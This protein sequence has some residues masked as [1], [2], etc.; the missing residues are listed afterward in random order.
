MDD[1]EQQFLLSSLYRMHVYMN[2][3]HR[4][5]M[6]TVRFVPG[7]YTKT[8]FSSFKFG[9]AFEVGFIQGCMHQLDRVL[10]QPPSLFI[11]PGVDCLMEG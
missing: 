8:G 5:R 10:N 7:F 11:S 9:V 2:S 4:S 6:T 1:A 3:F